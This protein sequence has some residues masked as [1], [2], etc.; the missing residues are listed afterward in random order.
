VILA[1]GVKLHIFLYLEPYYDGGLRGF[2][3]GPLLQ[4]VRGSMISEPDPMVI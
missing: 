1:Y 4:N 2:K 3:A